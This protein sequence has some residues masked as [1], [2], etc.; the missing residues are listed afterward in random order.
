MKKKVLTIV[1]FI[2][3]N[4]LIS[5]A[6]DT[7]IILHTKQSAGTIHKE[8]YGQ[9]AEHLLLCIYNHRTTKTNQKYPS[10]NL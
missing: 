10:V 3:S 8:L 6:E 4:T 9:F 1:L 2:L 5:F 7:K